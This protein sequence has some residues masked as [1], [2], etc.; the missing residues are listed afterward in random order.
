[1]SKVFHTVTPLLLPSPRSLETEG[2]DLDGEPL[3]HW[4]LIHEVEVPLGSFS[5]LYPEL[6]TVVDYNKLGIL[7]EHSIHDS[8]LGKIPILLS[9]LL[10]GS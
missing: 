6:L 1:M 5:E 9:N 8:S 3:S 4:N 2:L 10:N 7:L